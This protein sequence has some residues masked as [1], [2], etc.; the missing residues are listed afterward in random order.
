MPYRTG[1]QYLSR[2]IDIRL[3]HQTTALVARENID[4]WEVPSVLDGYSLTAMTI[5]VDTPSSSGA[6]TAQ[7]R[8]VTQGHDL[9][10]TLS[11]IDEG[12][13]SSM[14][15]ATPEVVNPAYAVLTAGDI[16]RF[17]LV[18]DGTGACGLNVR[19]VVTSPVIA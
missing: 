11:T 16:L 10:S 5:R 6:I 2:P 19:L 1:R 7:C 9:L 8:N 4:T 13:E 12:D 15:S 17:D 14:D 3:E 18:S